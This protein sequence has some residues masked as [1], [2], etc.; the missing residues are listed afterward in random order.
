MVRRGAV[1]FLVLWALT[2]PAF[3]AEET[4]PGLE[5]VYRAA[6]EYGVS[7][8][9]MF[10]GTVREGAQQLRELT[11]RAL[12]A[13]VK[14]VTVA[15]LCTLVQSMA[16]GQKGAVQAVELAGALAVTALAAGDVRA[17]I[18]LGRETVERIDAFSALLLPLMATLTA[19]AGQVGA[20][21]ARQGATVL[22]SD[23]LIRGM[24]QLL[25]PLLYLYMGACCACA[26]ADSSGLRKAAALIRG[27]LSGMLTV[28]LVLFVGWITA[29]GAVAGSA[30]AAAVKTAKMAISRAVPVVGGILSDAAETVLAGAGAL[31]GTVGVLGL[32]VVLA[33]CLVPFLQLAL[34]YLVYKGAAALAGMVCDMRMCKLIDD[35]GGA[36]GLMLGIA[37]AG[38]L[39]L[40]VSLISAISAAVP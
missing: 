39:V 25:I 20:A 27:G 33:I 19:A 3:G 29:S 16:Q 11:L 32:A 15:L 14:L 2:L 13:G 7:T 18:G 12:P 21:A 34:H 9:D 40:F 31:K 30:D 28:F 1:A 37:G 17:M 35:I 5:E 23:L 10:T 8:E 6:E 4:W 22:F 26:A 36:F 38:A 24:D